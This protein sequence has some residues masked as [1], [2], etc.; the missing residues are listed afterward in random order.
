[1]WS[2]PLL[3]N[4]S[5]ACYRSVCSSDNRNSRDSLTQIQT[6]GKRRRLPRHGLDKEKEEPVIRNINRDAILRTGR[7]E[8]V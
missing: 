4:A 8:C 2:L 5:L 6:T 7:Y 3:I 1:M